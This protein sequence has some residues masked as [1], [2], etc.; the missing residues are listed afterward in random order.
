MDYSWLLHSRKIVLLFLLIASMQHAH[1]QK[2]YQISLDEFK[3]EAPDIRHS[4]SEIIDAR[5]DK[6]TLGIISTGLN[7]KRNFAVFEKP[8]LTEIEQLLKNSGLYSQDN[9]LSLRITSL[10][11]SENALSWKETAKA[12]LSLDFFI[13]HNELYYYVSSVFVSAEPKGIDVTGKQAENIVDVVA[14]AL[15]VFSKQKNEVKGDRAFN[16]AELVDQTLCL[17]DPL[18][19][20][21]MKDEQYRDG[22]YATFEE[23]V[24][25]DPSIHIDC[26]IKFS[27]PVETICGDEVTEVPTLFGFAL[28]NK[29][30]ILY[31]HQFFELERK[32]DAFFFDANPKLSKN[33]ADDFTTATSFASMFESQR[34]NHAAI[35]MLDIKTGAVKGI[36]GF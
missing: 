35:Y 7:N 21:I 24:N 29:L 36:T 22:Y 33:S 1:S 28:Q 34:S 13:R 4:V 16:V 15:I 14:Q 18:S 2:L 6:F 27:S 8:G 11:I 3:I 32:N 25:N 19:M 31:H 23:F 10:K 17:R 5:K 20:P 9:G 26:E 12:E 30:Y